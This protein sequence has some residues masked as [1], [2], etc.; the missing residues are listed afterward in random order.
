MDELRIISA[1]EV[2]QKLTMTK[3]IEAMES[4]FRDLSSGQAIVPDRLPLHT[5][6]S[7]EY[8]FMPAYYPSG[9]ISTIKSVS[10]NPENPGR[11]RPFIYAT[12]QVF[13][14]NTGEPIA[15]V[16]GSSV[17][18]IRTAAASGLATKIFSNPES[19][20]AAIFGTG[21]QARTHVE[22]VLSVRPIHSILVYGSTLQ[23]S[24]SF[25]EEYADSEVEFTATDKMEDLISA[26]IICT[27]TTS[28][29]PVFD[30][31]FIK[32]GAHINAVGVYKPDY[33]EVPE[34]TVAAAKVYIDQLEG[35]LVEAGDLLI[36]LSKGLISQDHICNE[37]G[38]VLNGQL[39]YSWSNHKI[40]LFKSVGNAIQDAAVVSLLLD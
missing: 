22:A 36:P 2:R 28:S 8:L 6:Q 19:H 24:R 13:D 32:K 39:S 26:D 1:D 5:E 7:T 27:T 33:H 16:D 38:H 9:G 25:C 12:V 35:A 14:H 15:L 20:I 23:K 30:H 31:Q 34:E 3:A 11:G 4:A 40:T 29:T 18:A 21:V 37:I 17:T 10:I